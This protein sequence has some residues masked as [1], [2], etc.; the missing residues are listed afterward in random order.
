MAHGFGPRKNPVAAKVGAGGTANYLNGAAMSEAQ[1]A[2]SMANGV[3]PARVFAAAG[4]K[5]LGFNEMGTRSP[6]CSCVS[7]RSL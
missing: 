1:C 5:V 3:K 7:L 6:S 4:C 2:S